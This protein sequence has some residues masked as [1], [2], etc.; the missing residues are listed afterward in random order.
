MMRK[1]LS[2]VGA[3][4]QFIKVA[5]F[6]RSPH[7]QLNHLL[8]HT[9][10]H[11]DDC[12]SDIFFRD[13]ALPDPHYHLGVGS[14]SHGWQTGQ[15]LEKGEPGCRRPLCATL[16]FC[17]TQTAVENL[18]REGIGPPRSTVV[19][20]GDV[21]EEMLNRCTEKIRDPRFSREVLRSY[22]VSEKEYLLLTV[23]RAENTDDPSRLASILKGLAMTKEPVL[24][25]V[26]P[27]TAHTLKTVMSQ[28]LSLGEEQF[29]TD[30]IR[31]MEPVGYLEMLSLEAS[32]RMILTDS[33][34]V[35]KEAYLF[36]VPCLTL[37][38]E[39]EWVETVQNGWNRLVGTDP[40]RIV[41]GVRQFSSAGP[42]PPIF[43]SGS[44]SKKIVDE[45]HRFLEGTT[46]DD[47]PSVA[48]K[49][50]ASRME[51]VTGHHGEGQ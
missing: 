34:G 45:I 9:G 20:T 29:R 37:R 48:G 22:G 10:Q 27:R 44:P 13:L 12:M 36:N 18:K 8:V 42:P 16:L 51:K 41:T 38:E 33:G 2:I 15:M 35:Q 14:G 43:P 47:S 28:G 7:G 24:F 26:H 17:P 40:D 5:P 39:T 6:L 49:G 23:H 19:L 32:A 11:Y 4:P 1:V 31:F 25:P 50:M 30:S 46:A 3:R 21:M